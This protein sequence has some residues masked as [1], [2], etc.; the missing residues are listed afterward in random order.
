MSVTTNQHFITIWMSKQKRFM[1]IR[2][3]MVQKKGDKISAELTM[4]TI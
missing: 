4:E 1:K 3:E 2:T